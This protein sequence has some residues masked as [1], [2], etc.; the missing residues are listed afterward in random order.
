[1]SVP[2]SVY[3]AYET[4]YLLISCSI[5]LLPHTVATVNWIRLHG[6]LESNVSYAIRNVLSNDTMVYTSILNLTSLSVEQN[7]TSYKCLF[8]IAAESGLNN[9]EYII[10][11]TVNATSDPI[12]VKGIHTI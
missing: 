5:Q 10:P 4:G 12:I 2:G 7:N 8:N 3:A 9:S 1:M 6:S 11:A